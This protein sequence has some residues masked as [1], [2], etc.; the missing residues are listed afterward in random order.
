MA[1][2]TTSNK[3]NG[4]DMEVLRE[5]VA[6]IQQDPEL[7][8]AQFRARNKWIDANHNCTTVAGFYGAKAEHK[9]SH[10]F[11]LHADEPPVLAGADEAPNPV[12]HLLNALASCL[13]TSM[14]AHAAVRGVQ[15]QELESEVEGDIDL[16][17]YLGLDANVPCGYTNIR[18]KFRVKAD[19]ENMAKLK[20]LAEFSP[21]FNTI[22]QGA[23]VSVEVEPK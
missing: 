11:E 3:V 2:Q 14:V 18:V 9:H 22:S 8:K 15:I 5:T 12:E 7:G 21:V 4:I 13:T 6:A 19:T 10:P 23:D 1:T 16:R 17:G 20:R